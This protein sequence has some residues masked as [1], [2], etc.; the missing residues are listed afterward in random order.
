MSKEVYKKLYENLVKQGYLGTGLFDIPEFYNLVEELFTPE[1]AAV[2]SVQP[3]GGE[4]YVQA[5]EIATKIGWTENK[6]SATLESMAFKGTCTSIVK[7]GIRYYGAPHLHQISIIQFLRGTSTERDKKLAKLIYDF[8]ESHQAKT[9]PMSFPLSI[10]RV[11]SIEETIHVENVVHT[12]DQVSN[13]IENADPISVS[14]CFCR[15]PAK[16]LDPND[17]CDAPMEACMV[18]NEGAQFL[19]ERNMGRQVTKEEAYEILD[20]CEEANLIHTSANTQDIG[21]ICNCCMC[22]CGRLNYTMEQGKHT[23]SQVSSFQPRIT[24][25]ICSLCKSNRIC[26]ERC[27]TNALSQ[28]DSSVVVD[29]DLCIGCGLCVKGCK[30][31]AIV[32]EAKPDFQAPPQ[33][34]NGLIERMMKAGEKLGEQERAS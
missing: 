17:T 23:I 27:P 7:D 16:L 33:D 10:Y 22:H 18:F 4:N 2:A 13:Y 34:W 24:S 25:E 5:S 28:D 26:I 21:S 30:D 31:K 3:P 8:R 19:I 12:Y 20:A 29:I 32:M 14:A 15:H 1:E 6:V 9:G 11:I